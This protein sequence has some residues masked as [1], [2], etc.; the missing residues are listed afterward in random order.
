MVDEILGTNSC[1]KYQKPVVLIG[2][3]ISMLKIPSVETAK[4]SDEALTG[5]LDMKIQV[6]AKRSDLIV[7]L[8][9]QTSILIPTTIDN[10]RIEVQTYRPII[11][12]GISETMYRLKEHH[13]G[14]TMKEIQHSLSKFSPK[15]NTVVTEP[16]GTLVL[17]VQSI[18]NNV[19]CPHFVQPNADD[20]GPILKESVDEIL[21]RIRRSKR[22]RAMDNCSE[23]VQ[24]TSRT[25]EVLDRVRRAS[26]TAA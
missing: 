16:S 3:H 14:S 7:S 15:D 25:K 1:V 22:A 17:R 13:L 26:R 18:S 20:E 19:F 9:G 21:S 6:Y 12:N 4:D 10:Q 23:S 5:F 2:H 11:F 8:L 24:L